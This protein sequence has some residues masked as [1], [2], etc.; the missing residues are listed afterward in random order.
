MTKLSLCLAVGFIVGG[1]GRHAENKVTDASKQPADDAKL[2][3]D[4]PPPAYDFTCASNAPPTTAPAMINISGSAYA[5]DTSGA[6][7]LAGVTVTGYAEGSST[8]LASAVTSDGSGAWTL[9]SVPTTG[10][11]DGSGNAPLAAFIEANVGSG[12]TTYRTT[13]AYP[14]YPLT[15]NSDPVPTAMVST[16]D[17]QATSFLGTQDDTKNGALFVLVGDC[18][19]T[20]IQGATVNVTQD[21]SA[22]GDVLSLG[23]LSSQGA[24]IYLVL[25]VPAGPISITASYGTHTMPPQ[26]AVTAAAY[27]NGQMGVTNGAL[28]TTILVPGYLN[29]FP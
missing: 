8:P 3:A 29:G 4:A 14:P 13:F 11:S 7:P 9:E 22:V 19:D 23:T 27:K 16:A 15:A 17:W 6:T 5:V 20:P 12:S 2:Y 24:G 10:G 1:C 18:A 28:T 26:G 25:N 21:G